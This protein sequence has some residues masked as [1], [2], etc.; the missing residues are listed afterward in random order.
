MHSQVLE[1]NPSRVNHKLYFWCLLSANRRR[2]VSTPKSMI[3]RKRATSLVSVC[4]AGNE[5]S[6]AVDLKPFLVIFGKGIKSFSHYLIHVIGGEYISKQKLSLLLL[7]LLLIDCFS[8]TFT[9]FFPVFK[10]VHSFSLIICISTYFSFT[11]VKYLLTV[12]K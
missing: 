9:Y 11:P 1:F 7:F 5:Y 10:N 4:S 3:E 8:F 2:W 6:S 12:K